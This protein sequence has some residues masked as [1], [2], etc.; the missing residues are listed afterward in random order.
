MRRPFVPFNGSATSRHKQS[1]VGFITA[2]FGFRF[3]VHTMALLAPC[4]LFELLA[5][6]F[7]SMFF[8]FV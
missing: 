3:S 6:V 4:A 8:L 7:W 2:T 1:S 5:F